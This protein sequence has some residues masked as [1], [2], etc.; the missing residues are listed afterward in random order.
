MVTFSLAVPHSAANSFK[1]QVTWSDKLSPIP[2]RSASLT[3]WKPCI[4][5]K[6]IS[7]DI[8]LLRVPYSVNL[9]HPQSHDSSW[10]SSHLS[11]QSVFITSAHSFTMTIKQGHVPGCSPLMYV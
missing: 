9:L 6:K 10:V 3:M 8:N 7:R 4:P 2:L 11:S 5:L 1:A